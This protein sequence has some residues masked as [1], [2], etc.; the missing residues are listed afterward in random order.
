MECPNV[1]SGEGIGIGSGSLNSVLVIL[2]VAS[3]VAV[4]V[5]AG[6]GVK[7]VIFVVKVR[8]SGLVV[9]NVGA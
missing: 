8:F 5:G 2:P 4:D 7:D 6:G 1:L 3:E 9:I